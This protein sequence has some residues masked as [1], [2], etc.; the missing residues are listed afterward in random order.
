[1]VLGNLL[2]AADISCVIV[3][4]QSRAHVE[5]RAR[6]GFL[7]ANTVR[8]LEANGLAAGLNANGQPHDTCS[9]RGGHGQFELK[10]GAL[11]RGEIH[12]VYPQ[13]QLVADLIAEFLDRGGDIR[14][15]TPVTGVHDVTDDR[16]WLDCRHPDGTA[17]RLRGAYVA[18]CDGQHGVARRA[19]PLAAVREY[20]RDHDVTWLAILAQAPPSMA[21]V[22]YAVHDRGFAGQ[23]A[24]TATVTRYYLQVPRGEAPE[25]WGERRIWDELG[26]RMRTAEFGPLREGPILERLTVDLTATVREPMQYGR[27]FLVGDAAGVISPSA[28]KGANL[29]IMAAQTLATGLITAL[30]RDD[31][32]GL[33]HYSD[34]VLPRIWRAQEFSHWMINLLHAPGGDGDEAVFLRALQ[35]AQLVSLRDSRNHQDLFAEKYVGI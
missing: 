28:A 11:G 6:A 20:R 8:I 29:A 10:Y 25:R 1:M 2:R 27:L 7:A 19:L 22:A 12:T 13:Q 31:Q 15:G 35:R 30:T 24:R 23:M 3:E 17:Y 21:A 26:I 33:V 4:R 18:G 14:F 16:P 5:Q 9:F 34:D 32:R